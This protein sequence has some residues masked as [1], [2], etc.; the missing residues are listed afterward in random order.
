MQNRHIVSVLIPALLIHIS[1]CYSMK[2]IS[3]NDLVELKGE[4]DIFILTK[5]S[6][7]YSIKENCYNISNDTIHCWNGSVKK[8]KDSG[9]KNSS[10]ILI[11]I[12]SIERVNH[13]EIKPA[14]TTI[15]VLGSIALIVGIIYVIKVMIDLNNG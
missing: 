11:K 13:Y 7:S 2:E 3:R 14:S 15:L 10:N 12:S 1:G 8:F 5:D 9:F 4:G 6:T